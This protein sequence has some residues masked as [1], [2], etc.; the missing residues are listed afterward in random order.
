MD[1]QWVQQHQ[2]KKERG[3]LF[4]EKEKGSGMSLSFWQWPRNDKLK[5]VMQFTIQ[6]HTV[7]TVCQT[8]FGDLVSLGQKQKLFYQRPVVEEKDKQKE[9][10]CGQVCDSELT[11]RKKEHAKPNFALKYSTYSC[12]LEFRLTMS[13]NIQKGPKVGDHLS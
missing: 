1:Q 7:T 3:L 11:E 2:Y 13:D 5:S 8:C 12:R 4:G 10:R 6:T 9:N